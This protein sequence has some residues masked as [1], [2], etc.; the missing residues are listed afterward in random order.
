MKETFFS[1]VAEY[2]RDLVERND[3]RA[4][5]TTGVHVDNQLSNTVYFDYSDVSTTQT[6]FFNAGIG[7]G[8]D[9]GNITDGIILN[10]HITYQLTTGFGDVDQ[11]RIGLGGGL[12]F[13][14][15]FDIAGL[16]GAISLRLFIFKRYYLNSHW[17]MICNR[18]HGIR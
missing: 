12:G 2:H 18:S 13:G 6:G 15:N 7:M 16:I 9:Y 11:T 3:K 14:F 10:V 8:F 5:F 4:Y 17:K 1:L